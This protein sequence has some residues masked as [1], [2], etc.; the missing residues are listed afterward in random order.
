VAEQWDGDE[1][2][3]RRRRSGGVLVGRALWWGKWKTAGAMSFRRVM[4]C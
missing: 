4:W 3:L 1:A 2:K